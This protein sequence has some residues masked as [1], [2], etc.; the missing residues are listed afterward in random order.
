MIEAFRARNWNA[1]G[2]NLCPS[3][4][5][6]LA[7]YSAALGA[8][9]IPWRQDPNNASV[10]LNEV[11]L[12]VAQR[13][14]ANQKPAILSVSPPQAHFILGGFPSGQVHEPLFHDSW[15]IFGMNWARRVFDFLFQSETRIV[16]PTLIEE[17]CG[18]VRI[19]GPCQR[20]D[21]VDYKANVVN[22]S[23]FFEA[24]LHKNAIARI[25]DPYGGPIGPKLHCSC[26]PGMTAELY[27]G[28]SKTS[29]FQLEGEMVSG[30]NAGNRI[31]TGKRPSRQWIISLRDV[32]L[33]EAARISFASDRLKW[34]T[35][36]AIRCPCTTNVHTD[37]SYAIGRLGELGI[38]RLF[39]KAN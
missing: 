25:I 8:E 38:S 37:K 33:D 10:P 1:Y 36:S 22:N 18:A 28:R 23:R 3:A 30:F 7:N 26:P 24:M 19:S 17:V 16:Q 39:Q 4:H 13:H 31:G 2:F 21:G 32:D 20:R 35:R 12:L 14:G 6:W 15:K 29:S 5:F 27:R 9:M 34:D 11:S